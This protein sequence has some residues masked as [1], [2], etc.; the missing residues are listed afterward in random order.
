MSVP[1][2]QETL[3]VDQAAAAAERTQLSQPSL[4][5]HEPRPRER[6]W[7]A[8]GWWK[9]LLVAI[10]LFGTVWASYN[11]S[12][13]SGMVLDNKYIIEEY[14]KALLR[15]DAKH[16]L[17]SWKQIGLIFQNDY[18]WPKGI[19][20]LYR[21]ITTFTYWLDYAVFT[22]KPNKTEHGRPVLDDKKKPVEMSW[23]E[24]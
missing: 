7:P 1:S 20:G 21:P 8:M 17:L 11:N 23:Y 22:G 18:W 6:M 3:T 15:A 24:Y 5:P 2:M 14:Y 9:H 19:S 12:F 4:E 13:Q 10:A 16:E